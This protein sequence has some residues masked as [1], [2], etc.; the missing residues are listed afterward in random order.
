MPIVTGNHLS[1]NMKNENES[2]DDVR[3]VGFVRSDE[4]VKEALKDRLSGKSCSPTFWKRFSDKES[5]QECENTDAI[6]PA[7]NGHVNNA[8]HM[9]E[10]ESCYCSD[11]ITRKYLKLVFLVR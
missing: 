8:F 2:F 7:T 4:D 10:P 11:R 1:Y 3:L 5:N 6:K 9:N